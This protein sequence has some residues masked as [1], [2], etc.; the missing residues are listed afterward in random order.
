MNSHGE[1][2]QYAWILPFICLVIV[3]KQDAVCPLEQHEHIWRFQAFP[4]DKHVHFSAQLLSLRFRNHQ[5][6]LIQSFS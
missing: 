6:L 3:K 5:E 4:A 1:N 2:P